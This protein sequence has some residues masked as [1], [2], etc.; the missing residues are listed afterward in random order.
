M[1]PMHPPKKD[2]LKEIQYPDPPNFYK[3]YSKDAIRR[4]LCFP[5]PPLP[6]AFQIFGE[7][8]DLKAP[9]IPPVETKGVQRVFGEINGIADIRD[10]MLKINRSIMAAFIDLTQILIENPQ[11]DDRIE[12]INNI[13]VLFLN[14]HNLINEL[15]P[16]QARATLVANQKQTFFKTQKLAY[17]ITETLAATQA[18]L[19]TAKLLPRKLPTIPVPLMSELDEEK[20]TRKQ[21]QEETYILQNWKDP[22]KKLKERYIYRDKLVALKDE[23]IKYETSDDD[24][25]DERTDDELDSSS[26]SD[27]DG[28]EEEEED[29][30]EIDEDEQQQEIEMEVDDDD[31]AVESAVNVN[32][33]EE[34]EESDI[35]YSSVGSPR[36]HSPPP[37]EVQKLWQTSRDD[38]EVI[39][40]PEVQ[41]LRR[42]IVDDEREILQGMPK[43]YDLNAF[44]QYFKARGVAPDQDEEVL[45]VLRKKRERIQK[46]Q[47]KEVF[48]SSDSEDSDEEEEGEEEEGSKEPPK[49]KQRI[50][51]M[52]VFDEDSMPRTTTIIDDGDDDESGEEEEILELGEDDPEKEALTQ[53]ELEN[54]EE[55]DDSDAT[56][57]SSDFDSSDFSF[58]DFSEVQNSSDLS[59]DSSD[60]ETFYIE[61]AIEATIGI[62]SKRRL[63]K[64]DEEEDDEEP[65]R[66]PRKPSI[67]PKP[68]QIDTSESDSDLEISR[69]SY[70]KAVIEEVDSEEESKKLSS[71]DSDSEVIE[72]DPASGSTIEEDPENPASEDDSD[73]LL[74]STPEEEEAEEDD[75]DEAMEGSDNEDSH[76]ATDEQRPESLQELNRPSPVPSSSSPFDDD[77]PPILE[78]EM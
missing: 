17:D 18:A 14:F 48:L 40:E 56:S 29:V 5:P 25:D 73:A 2:P 26:S 15:R 44:K 33:E 32:S 58:S 1:Y 71:D 64:A 47:E 68:V 66:K 61:S 72:P 46:L 59:S 35:E 50:Q 45:K 69:K 36:Y 76:E 77:Q 49:K 24:A 20:K 3:N 60:D 7:V 37:P 30:E 9:V 11:S 27:N 53:K 31:D 28:E 54:D 39:D 34:S 10:H 42:E 41:E 74:A 21:L 67:K 43:Y 75:D 51:V 8:Y 4:G 12:K 16:I 19:L 78:P 23:N 65:L 62:P 63:E 52:E 38:S 22:P 6:A 13:R 70:K 55:E 57:D